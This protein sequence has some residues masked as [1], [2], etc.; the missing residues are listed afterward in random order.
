M[1]IYS[2]RIIKTT[3]PDNGELLNRSII[4]DVEL[5]GIRTSVGNIDPS[6]SLEQVQQYLTANRDEIIRNA[7]KAEEFSLLETEQT[8][9]ESAIAS[10]LPSWSQVSTVVHSISSLAGAKAFLMKLARVVYW[11]AKDQAD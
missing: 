10:N 1:K 4:L 5:D 8:K 9:K 11:I 2:A 3:D 7:S 6:W